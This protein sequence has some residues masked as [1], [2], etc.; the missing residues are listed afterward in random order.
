MAPAVRWQLVALICAALVARALADDS[1]RTPEEREIARQM[2]QGTPGYGAPRPP[3]T[4]LLNMLIKNEAA[5]L[6]RTLPKWAKIIDYWIIGVDDKNTDNSPEVITK[7]LGH[8]PGEMVTVKFDGMGPTWTILVERGLKDFPNATHGIVA[9]ADFMPLVD[10][11]DKMELDIRCSK[12]MYTIWTEDHK[13]SRKMDW[14]YRNIPG[15]KVLRRTHQTV[16][17][18]DLPYQ[19]VYQTLINL[20]VEERTGGYQDRTPGKNERYIQF[21][22][23]DLRDYPND[24]RTL[25]YLGYAY[26][27]M[28][29]KVWDEGGASVL[30][31][32]DWSNLAKGV[33]Y[34]HWRLNVTG[35]KV[36]AEETWFTIL[37]LGEINERFY[38]NWPQAEMHYL[39]C[40]KLD[41]E[42]ADPWFYLGQHH[43][44]HGRFHE[45]LPYL[46]TGS[47]LLSPE[48][49]LFH[50]HY[51]YH[52]LT[53]VEFAR[54]VQGLSNEITVDLAEEAASFLRQAD[55]A[56][57]GEQALINEHKSLSKFFSTWL[58]ANKKGEKK[59]S[60]LR[61]V[62]RAIKAL[63]RHIDSLED[64]LGS[65]QAPDEEDGDATLFDKLMKAIKPLQRLKEKY[66]KKSKEDGEDATE[67]IPCP[68]FR[69]GTIGVLQFFKKNSKAVAA[70]LDED[71]REELQ[72]AIE[73]LRLHCRH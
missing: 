12:H 27:D 65:V 39:N 3:G 57:E 47:K 61:M 30:K 43:R 32:E 25:Y 50:W 28:F 36:N 33:E 38:N 60:P 46:R 9:D 55:C 40:T 44:L 69:R 58:A 15:A 14:I 20:P 11:L 67:E 41:P 21:L 48:R 26:F 24:P 10:H 71:E 8:I 4:L 73:A 29:K 31:P 18:P 17:V 63:S 45:A 42:R 52:C 37:K 72:L 5:H 53:K 13:N 59:K 56:T 1:E 64:G 54:A 62:R 51:L 16:S 34:M 68:E 35:P 23:A 19:E 70:A 6:D 2:R 7:H 66:A 49:S 22:L